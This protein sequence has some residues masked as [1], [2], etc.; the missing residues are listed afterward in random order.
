MTQQIL[1]IGTNPNDGTG[2][3]VRTAM[4][5]VQNNFSDLYTNYVSNAQL[6]A[7]LSN[8]QT[9]AGLSANVLTMI[10]N[11]TTY[12]GTVSA[13]NVVSNAQLS[14]NL[15]NY[16]TTAG[17]VANIAASTANNTNFVG[18][19]SAANVVSNAQ[20]SANLSAL[21]STYQ[22][23]AGLA[24]NVATLTANNTSYVGTVTAANVV[25]NAQLS[26]NL[27]ALSSVYQTMAGLSSNVATLT[28][29]NTSYVGTVSAVNV[30]SNAQLSANLAN[31]TT[32]ALAATQLSSNLALYQTLTGLASNVAL[33]AA[34]TARYANQSSTNTFTVGTSAYFVTNGN[35]GIATS[36][37][38]AP[39]DIAGNVL[40]GHTSGNGYLALVQGT[41]INT[42]YMAFYDPSNNR[43][44]YIGY[45]NT[46]NGLTLQA[47]NYFMRFITNGTEAARIDTSQNFHI[48][49]TTSVATGRV[50]A[51]VSSS[52]NVFEADTGAISG[53][54]HFLVESG[55]SSSGEIGRAHV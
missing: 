27:S 30:V 51:S 40:A 49:T 24:A 38:I 5:K 12:V 36:T 20:L 19:V 6:I 4:I 54:T 50:V 11:N 9:T 8:Y 45:A 41:P 15:S 39:L 48:G 35:V 10:A 1:N 13:A 25:S 34:N 14:A 44:G 52:Q 43:Q 29:N 16:Q 46:V 7:N 37:P 2:D 53:M 32:T 42:G 18:T 3:P 33:L 22:T 47:D 23:I 26:A 21:S 17:L 55:L 31:Y 28:S